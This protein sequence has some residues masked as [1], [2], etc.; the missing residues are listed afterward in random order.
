MFFYIHCI[1]SAYVLYILQTLSLVIMMYIDSVRIVILVTLF[2]IHEQRKV[3]YGERVQEN[4]NVQF[5]I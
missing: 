2:Q 4:V 1:N 3:F 5:Y